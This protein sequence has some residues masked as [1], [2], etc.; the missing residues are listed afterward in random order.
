M[1]NLV[2]YIYSD[3]ANDISSTYEFR[4]SAAEFGYQIT[5]VANKKRHVGN[6]EVLRLLYAAY[7]ELSGPV[8]YADGADS[9]FL[10]A[11][12]VP[13]DRILYSTEKAIW[14][15][16]EE[17]KDAWEHHPKASHWAYLNGGGYA[18]PAELITEYFE[19]YGLTKH[20]GDA[21]GQWQQAVAY[22]R[23]KS[24][25]FPIDLDQDCNEFQTIGF[26]A[27]EDFSCKQ[28]ILINNW[29]GT[30]PALIHGNGRT[31]MQWVYDLMP[32]QENA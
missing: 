12:V 7:K 3:F 22:L 25:G 17:L 10:R 4:R 24:D 20:L 32:V 19:R 5:N 29:T 28:G 15:P 31:P 1:V 2:T 21:N 26:T 18:G 14:P 11:M 9:F 13:H 6:G 16:V 27:P 23:A 8:I 30:T